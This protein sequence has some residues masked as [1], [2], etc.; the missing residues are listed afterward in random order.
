MRLVYRKNETVNGDA[1]GK[2]GKNEWKIFRLKKV[3]FAPN[4]LLFFQLKKCSTNFL[5]IFFQL[6]NFLKYTFKKKLFLPN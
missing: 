2:D 1:R 5:K 3:F 6:K 4:F